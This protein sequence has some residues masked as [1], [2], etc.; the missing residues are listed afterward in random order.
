MQC[1]YC[2]KPVKINDIVKL[3]LEAYSGSAR[4]RTDCCGALIMVYPII[5]FW[6]TETEQEGKDDWGN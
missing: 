2:D 6:C 5:S 4:A 1:P 3:N